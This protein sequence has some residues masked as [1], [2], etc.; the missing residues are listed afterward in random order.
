MI[1]YV[2]IVIMFLLRCAH[3]EKFRIMLETMRMR[4]KKWWMQTMMAT[5]TK[6][7]M[8]KFIFVICL[9]R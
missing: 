4:M 3:V 8:S 6:M 1:Q 9:V 2:L 7:R 5:M